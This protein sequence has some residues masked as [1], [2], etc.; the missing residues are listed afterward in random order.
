[1]KRT[2]FVKNLIKQDWQSPDITRP[3]IKYNKN[4]CEIRQFGNSFFLRLFFAENMK[5]FLTQKNREIKQYGNSIFTKICHASG[6][7]QNTT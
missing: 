3:L 6:G 5:I 7:Q 4:N 1:M 2:N